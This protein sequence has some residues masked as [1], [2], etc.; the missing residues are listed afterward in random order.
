MKTHKSTTITIAV[1]SALSLFATPS[2]SELLVQSHSEGSEI[3]V[4]ALKVQTSDIVVGH[5][6]PFNGLHDASFYFFTEDNQPLGAIFCS[7]P[8]RKYNTNGYEANKKPVNHPE[9]IEYAE[10]LASNAS[11]C[12][13]LP[14]RLNIGKNKISYVRLD[15]WDGTKAA[16]GWMVD[17]IPVVHE[18]TLP[19]SVC[20]VWVT[21]NIQYGS[22]KP[23]S[24]TT[25]TGTVRVTC[26]QQATVSISVNDNKPLTIDNGGEITFH[27]KRDAEVP[28]GENY[29]IPIT[30]VMSQA[31]V[32]A[33]TYKWF[34]VVR[35]DYK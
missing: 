2:S 22:L 18:N 28:P 21:K 24:S 19:P 26:E 5:Y 30:A 1:L 31:P 8:K 7:L 12:D 4:T 17:R 32:I 3:E 10:I 6:Y 27:Y 35:I 25:E 33:G 9:R 20:S 14:A 16:N 15:H 11:A 23:G 34:A 29:S 13:A